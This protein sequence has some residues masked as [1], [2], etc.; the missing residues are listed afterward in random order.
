MSSVTA[1]YWPFGLVPRATWAHHFCARD[2]GG[3]ACHTGELEQLLP[4]CAAN[5]GVPVANKTEPKN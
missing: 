3:S 4:V 5:L 2:Q 1:L